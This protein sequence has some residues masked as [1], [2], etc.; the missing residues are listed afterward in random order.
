M[1]AELI[2]QCNISLA[3]YEEQQHRGPK[4]PHSGSESAMPRYTAKKTTKSEGPT[5]AVNAQQGVA[6][7][8]DMFEKS[9]A[10]AQGTSQAIQRVT[11]GAADFNA[12]WIEMALANTDATLDFVRQLA[13]VKSP[14]EF[15]ELSTAHAREQFDTFTKQAQHLAALAQKVTTDAVRPLQAGAKSALNKVA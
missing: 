5:P 12:Q 14:S 4:V 8:R 3:I 7:S 13:E 11:K 10:A 1:V 2:L 6:Y 15:L 9:K